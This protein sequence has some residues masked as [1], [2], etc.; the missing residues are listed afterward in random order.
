MPATTSRT[1]LRSPEAM[2][3]RA[4]YNTARWRRRR[5]VQ[6]RA[7]PFCAMCLDQLGVYTAASVADHIEPHKGDPVKFWEGK[8]QSLC[9]PHHDRHKK[10]IEAGRPVLGC[11]ETGWPLG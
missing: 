9:K 7:E 1:Y 11:D 2:V 10:L 3:Y 4:W 8:L 6:L 5:K